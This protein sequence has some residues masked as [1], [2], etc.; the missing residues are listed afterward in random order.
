MEQE[1][2]ILSLMEFIEHP[3]FCVCDGKVRLANQSARQHMIAE[4]MEITGLLSADMAAY[5]NYTGGELALT[6][7]LCGV[8]YK[9]QVSRIGNYDLFIIKSDDLEM[10][11]IALAAQ[12][13][14]TPLNSIMV[15]ADQI[16]STD[17]QFKGQLQKG[18]N[19]LHRIICNMS[20]SYRYQQGNAAHLEITNI[21]SVFDECMEAI[22]TYLEGCGI[23]LEYSGLDTPIWGL[24]DRDM[25]ERAA[26]NLVSNGIKFMVGGSILRVKL[27]QKG[28]SLSFTVQTATENSAVNN[29]YN[30]YLREPSVEDSRF[31]IGLGMPLVQAVAAAHGGTVLTDHPD[32]QTVRITMTISI[33][34]SSE[35]I[36]RSAVR[37][38]ISN[39]AGGRD[40]GLME[41]SDV[42]PADIYQKN[43]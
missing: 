30:R 19:R 16:S 18:L 26:Y 8:A 2:M 14:R 4:D 24:A 38:P 17:S 31:G 21:T 29:L 25:L 22:S 6:V 3:A 28:N 42:L 10:R 9:A 35:N 34:E 43:T 15:V 23:G 40:R 41:L 39:Y 5:E 36:V 33:K 37:L 32:S 27:S 7:T 1:N 20:D 11:A 12:N 13:L